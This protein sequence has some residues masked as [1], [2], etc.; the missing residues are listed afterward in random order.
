MRNTLLFF[1]FVYCV[2]ANAQTFTQ[3]V[4]AS[5]G[6]YYHQINGSLQFTI[7]EP[8]TEAYSNTSARLFNGFEQGS[9]VILAV[10]EL[11]AI[12]DLNVTLFP[13][14]SSG[15][16]NLNIDS[17]ETSLFKVDIIDALGKLVFQKEITA[18]AI[19]T[20][21]LE[22]NRSA[23]YFVTVSNTKLNYIKSFKIIKQ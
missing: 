14:P 4:N 6:G 17:K 19:E 3:E 22:N 8:I 9:Y 10:N 18:N 16:I 11:P 15:I 23:I 12:A 7:G 20:I 1:F 21:N 13:N 5:G 2:S